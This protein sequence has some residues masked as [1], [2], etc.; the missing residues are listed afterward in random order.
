MSNRPPKEE[1]SPAGGDRGNASQG[2]DLPSDA[3]AINNRGRGWLWVRRIALVSAVV[4]S[5]SAGDLTGIWA[6]TLSDDSVLLSAKSNQLTVLQMC[7][8]N[9]TRTR[10]QAYC[11]ESWHNTFLDNTV[12]LPPTKDWPSHGLDVEGHFLWLHVF[13]AGVCF[14]IVGVHKL[15]R[16][17]AGDE[18]RSLASNGSA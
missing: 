15:W 6:Y 13:L 1:R 12:R 8:G 5:C 17:W 2:P 11:E 3:D 14:A 4:F 9:M 16:E 7:A 10:D 18:R